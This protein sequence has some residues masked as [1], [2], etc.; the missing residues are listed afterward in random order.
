VVED[1][2]GASALGLAS[3][4]DEQAVSASRSV[5]VMAAAVLVRMVPPRTLRVEGDIIG[6]LG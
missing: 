3:S 2:A 6:H 4:L 5:A 1:G